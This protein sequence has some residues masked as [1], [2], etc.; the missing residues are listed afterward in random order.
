MNRFLPI[1]FLMLLSVGTAQADE[2]RPAFLDL[3]QSSDEVFEVLWKVPA[4]GGQRLS[5]NVRFPPNVAKVS[6]VHASMIGGAYIE[7][8][9]INS[10]GGLGGSEITIEGLSAVST[11]VLVRIE[12][13]DGIT[14][15][16]RLLL[17]LPS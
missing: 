5:L 3:R 9:S 12:R 4:L 10:R 8:Y 13:L 17:I 14:I 15:V 11:E 16:A 6:T 1:A 2:Y 7:R